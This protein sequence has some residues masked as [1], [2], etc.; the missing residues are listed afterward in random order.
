[1]RRRRTRAKRG[2]MKRK[3]DEYT[4][5]TEAFYSGVICALLVVIDGHDQPTIGFEIL[6]GCDLKEIRR[7]AKR[8]GDTSIVKLVDDYRRARR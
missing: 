3:K 4:E 5:W 6:M 2:K 8:E 7:I 1:M